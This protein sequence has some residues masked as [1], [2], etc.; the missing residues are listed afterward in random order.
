MRATVRSFFEELKKRR[1]YRAALGYLV[2]GWL[3][4]QVGATV[5]PVFEAPAWVLQLIIVLVALGLPAVM[6]VAWAFDL[7]STSVASQADARSSVVRRGAWHLAIIGLVGGALLIGAYVVWG[8]W[9]TGTGQ[10]AVGDRLWFGSRAS[11][12]SAPVKSI[13]VLPF[14]NLSDDKAN[15]Y[16]ADGIHDE[17]LTALS[18]LA[19]LR[20]IS[21]TSVMQYKQS[22]GRNLREVADALNVAHVLEGSVRR[23]GN[24]IRVTA[25]L[26]DARTDAHLWADS[27]DRDVADVFAI[28]SEIAQRIAEQL[29]ATLSPKEQANFQAKP[30]RDLAAYEGYLQA[31]EIARAGGANTAEKLTQQVSLL[32]Q[33]LARDPTFVPALCLSA[34]AHL[35]MYW[36]NH[37]H[38]AARLDL[39]RRAL[40]TAARLQPDSGDVHL[41]RAILHYWGS[42]DYAAALRELELARRAVPNDAEMVLFT[43]LIERR[44]GQWEQSTAHLR[45][46]A[47]MDPRNATIWFQLG[48]LN[49]MALKRY[50]EAAGAL[51]EVLS[52]KPN[53]FEFERSR[54]RVDVAAR[55]DLARLRQVVTSD[56]AKEAELGAV[57]LTRME[58]ALAQRDYAAAAAALS[59]HPLPNFTAAGFVTPREWYE[60]IIAKGM[61][62]AEKARVAFLAAR[63]QA[64][65]TAA[66][67]PDDAKA[68]IVLSEIDARLGNRSEAIRGGEHALSLLPPSRD[69]VDGPWMITRL[70][71]IYAQLGDHDRAL[72]LLSQAAKLPLGPSYGLLKLDEV[73]DPLRGDARFDEIVAT[74]APR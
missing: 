46:A 16:F 30:P 4:I 8:P 74:L 3:I 27:Y 12:A 19:D 35:A 67:R 9:Q 51:E 63:E 44:I 68:V 41:T 61:G 43:A 11:S 70:A 13:A 5:L 45:E 34:R 47:A 33:A 53:D 65:Q 21:R 56:A 48:D 42:R 62:D 52:W 71:G 38:T 6:V 69:A 50:D 66:R 25:Q 32:D 54:A 60:A 57:T 20:V 17:I 18:K 26:I 22:G 14:D 28:Q 23:A 7:S 49:L 29:Q 39:A 59:D 1:V 31:K 10:R 73:W 55:A 64:A 15:A 24:R 40:E 2:V 72:E 58:L 37:D 36:F